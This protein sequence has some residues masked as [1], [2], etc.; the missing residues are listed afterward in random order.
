M[1]TKVTYDC[2][3]LDPFAIPIN[4]RDLP[5]HLFIN[6][7][8]LLTDLSGFSVSLP[9]VLFLLLS[10]LS[11]LSASQRSSLFLK[12]ALYFETDSETNRS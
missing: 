8:V 9:P 6:S 11:A 7:T 2:F 5:F 3:L 4:L 12:L 10:T 1:E